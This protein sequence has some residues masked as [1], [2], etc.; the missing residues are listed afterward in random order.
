VMVLPAGPWYWILAECDLDG[1][2][3]TSRYFVNSVNS[4]I[5]VD[6]EGE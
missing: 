1:D 5:Q 3:T 4:S 2:G 6:N